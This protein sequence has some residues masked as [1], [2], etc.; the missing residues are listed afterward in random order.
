MKAS[1]IDKPEISE[2]KGQLQVSNFLWFREML[3]GKAWILRLISVNK[4]LKQPSFGGHLLSL[5]ATSQEE[6]FI[7][8]YLYW[9]PGTGWKWAFASWIKG[10]QFCEKNPSIEQSQ[11]FLKWLKSVCLTEV[12]VWNYLKIPSKLKG[13]SLTNVFISIKTY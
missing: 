11:Q 6:A 1:K 8:Y 5:K 3:K 13:F 10:T 2:D 7:F 9:S 12:S 4:I